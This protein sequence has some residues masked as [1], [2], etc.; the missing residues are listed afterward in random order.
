MVETGP[1]LHPITERLSGRASG[2]VRALNE[3]SLNYED[4][5]LLETIGDEVFLSYQLSPE[6]AI[7]GL[8]SK[9][10]KL[11]DLAIPLQNISD[12][13]IRSNWETANK[14]LR[15]YRQQLHSWNCEAVF[16]GSMIFGHPD[17]ADLDLQIISKVNAIP[18]NLMLRLEKDLNH[19]TS[20]FSADFGFSF[21]NTWI[22]HL[23]DDASYTDS[24]KAMDLYLETLYMAPVLYGT[25]YGL[26]ETGHMDRIRRNILTAAKTYPVAGA[27]LSYT[28]DFALDRVLTRRNI[29]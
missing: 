16:F 22:K 5:L 20:G 7:A 1:Q 21:L 10:K 3:Y 24:G 17:K 12:A 11:R 26:L 6:H 28:L 25:P 27:Q 18:N 4:E 13:R 29:R 8:K 2:Y 19:R 9:I 23:E 15:E 14:F